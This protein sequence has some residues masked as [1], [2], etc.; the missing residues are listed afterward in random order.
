[1]KN[2]N[3]AITFSIDQSLKEILDSI[4]NI[5]GWWSEEIEG[6]TDKIIELVPGRNG[7]ACIGQLH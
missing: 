4:N 1:M 7:M 6:S 5:R 3:F 2:Q